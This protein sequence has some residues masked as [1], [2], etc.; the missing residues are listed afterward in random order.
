MH[1]RWWLGSLVGSASIVA[2]LAVLVL[3]VGSGSSF[4]T[5]RILL[6]FLIDLVVVLGLQMFMGMTG[7]VSLG[8][9]GFMA[10]GAYTSALLTT[11]PETKLLFIPDAPGLIR[12]V[13][14]GFAP[15]ILIAV[16]LAMAVG[17]V[18]GLAVTRLSGLAA[19]LATYGF[20][21]AVAGVIVGLKTITLGARTFGGVPLYT[22][23]ARAFLAVALAVLIGR[24]VRDSMLGL[25]LRASRE[26]ETA[27]GASGVDVTMSRLKVWVL[28]GAV[29]AAGGALYAHF[30]GSLSTTPFGLTRT[31]LYLTMAIVGGST[32]S[33]AV[34]GVTTV[35]ALVEVFRR[36]AGLSTFNAGGAELN[37]T[38][39]T[40]V[41]LALLILLVVKFLPRGLLGIWELDEWVARVWRARR[42]A[43]AK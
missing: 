33:G 9:V 3:I 40:P 13:S 36:F 27:A 34:V 38:V 11:P 12:D 10:L 41:L 19:S 26:D 8:H 30:V 1:S 5:D 43:T 15:A 24:L 14:M 18:V 32:I 42:A 37:V 39:L 28:S 16:A 6:G 17:V 21:V 29:S 4:S 2:P 35:T 22:T 7:I 31:L 23:P 20:L 25:G